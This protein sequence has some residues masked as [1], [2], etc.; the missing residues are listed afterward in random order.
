VLV[1]LRW[2][3]EGKDEDEAFLLAN[4]A[5]D[6]AFAA[7]LEETRGSRDKRP[8]LESYLQFYIDAWKTLSDDRHIDGMGGFGSIQYMTIRAYAADNGI[9]GDDFQVFH[10]FIKALDAEYLSW[11]SQQREKNREQQRNGPTS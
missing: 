10:A 1:V 3:L 8:D 9:N 6:P 4:A 11:V 7:H 2:Q 5:E